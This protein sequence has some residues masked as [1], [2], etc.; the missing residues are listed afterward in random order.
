[1]TTLLDLVTYAF[2][3]TPDSM[4]DDITDISL[5]TDRWSDLLD[6]PLEDLHLSRLDL[7]E[8]ERDYMQLTGCKIC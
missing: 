1:M 4:C 2:I 8:M 7:D 5:F 6:T 3:G